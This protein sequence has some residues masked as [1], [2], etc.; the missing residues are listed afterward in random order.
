[1]MPARDRRNRL[2]VPDLATCSGLRSRFLA[3]ARD[4]TQPVH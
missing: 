3:P 4:E 2:S 1:M